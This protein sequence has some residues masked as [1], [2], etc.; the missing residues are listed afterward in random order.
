M[1]GPLAFASGA[2]PASTFKQATARQLPKDV[3]HFF[4][5]AINATY[6]EFEL[7]AKG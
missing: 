4:S 1:R 5:G 3:L 7:C 2:W 6:F